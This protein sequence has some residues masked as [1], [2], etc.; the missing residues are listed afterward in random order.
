[1]Q[2]TPCK[3]GRIFTSWSFLVEKGRNSAFWS[4]R[5]SGKSDPAVQEESEPK[6]GE[7]EQE[8]K[9]EEDQVVKLL[10]LLSCSSGV[11][12]SDWSF[13]IRRRN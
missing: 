10:L 13:C 12:G 3:L 11:K 9:V 5:E 4:R 6:T 2:A 8:E 1:M 7:D